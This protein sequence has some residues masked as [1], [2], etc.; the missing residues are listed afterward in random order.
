LELPPG[1]SISDI[2]GGGTSGLA[3][4]IPRTRTVL[5]FS[6][7][8]PDEC[9]RCEREA[10]IYE[11]L[12]KST[13]PRPPSLLEYQGR[14]TCGRGILLQYAENNTVRRY[15]GI[16]NNRLASS[17]LIPRWAHQA[18]LALHF[19]HMNDAAH[20]DVTCDNFFLDEDYNLRLGD[21][22]NSSLGLSTF[23]EQDDIFEFGLALYEMSTGIQLFKGL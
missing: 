6:H 5:K 15:L 19:V 7:G 2:I 3:A 13:V 10:Q 1:I 12:S 8:D 23:Q 17:V 18:A 14:S 4:L 9:G 16:P 20:G 11:L 21:F 22:T